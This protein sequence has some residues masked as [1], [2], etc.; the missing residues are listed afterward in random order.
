MQRFDYYSDGTED[1][2]YVIEIGH[3]DQI[4]KEEVSHPRQRNALR[5]R[6]HKRELYYQRLEAEAMARSAEGSGEGENIY[7]FGS[8]HGGE[9][10]DGQA[11]D[12]DID[13]P[14]SKGWRG[15]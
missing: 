4:W 3:R 5:S 1:V 14:Q 15:G 9:D 7:Q 10:L 12:Q 8:P 13:N 6:R 2:I 11:E